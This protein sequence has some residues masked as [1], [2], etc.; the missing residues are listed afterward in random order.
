MQIALQMSKILIIFIFSA[1]ASDFISIYRLGGAKWAVRVW[2]AGEEVLFP[3]K[4]I[5]FA[6]RE[7]LSGGE[8]GFD[9][10]GRVVSFGGMGACSWGE[11]NFISGG[12]RF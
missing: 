5:G 1:I 8:R 3:G 10:A 4:R 12:E 6:G 7:V 11:G 2:S 9:F